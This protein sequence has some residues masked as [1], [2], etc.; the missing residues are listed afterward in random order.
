MFNW[1]KIIVLA[2]IFQISVDVSWASPL[3]E[4][5]N[6]ELQD[7]STM[8]L[9]Q[10][11]DPMQ[12]SDNL[13]ENTTKVVSLQQ[14][15]P[16]IAGTLGPAAPFVQPLLMAIVPI[17]NAI[18]PIVN[19]VALQLLTSLFNSLSNSSTQ[20]RTDERSNETHATAPTTEIMAS[21]EMST[22]AESKTEMANEDDD[23]DEEEDD[24]SAEEVKI[25]AKP[26]VLGNFGNTNENVARMLNGVTGTLEEFLL[27]QMQI[28][29]LHDDD[30]PE[31]KAVYEKLKKSYNKLLAYKN[32][33][34]KVDTN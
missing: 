12:Y 5:S 6:N 33:I 30:G 14:V 29:S 7:I 27:E 32:S 16:L 11:V 28:Q 24:T 4:L 2:L 3:Q 34:K 26:L 17:T 20:N 9:K 25:D 10:Y 18:R 15:I 23:D 13:D 19:R 21:D 22:T 1:R 31:K 8:D